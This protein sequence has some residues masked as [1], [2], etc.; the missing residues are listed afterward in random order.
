M[1]VTREKDGTIKV[2][3]SK[4]ITDMAKRFGL[5]DG[6][7]VR[8][9]DTP[10]LST[11]STGQDDDRDGGGERADQQHYMELIGSLM[12]AAIS[13]RYDAAYKICELARHVVSPCK[14]HVNEAMRVL[15]YLVGTKEHCLVFK[16][17]QQTGTDQSFTVEAWTDSDWASNTVHRKST[18]GWI[19]RVNGN[20]VSWQS[21]LQANVALSSCEAELYAC[22]TGALE[23][24]YLR[25]LLVELGLLNNNRSP[26]SLIHMDNQSAM[27]TAQNGIR[28]SDRNKHV[29]VRYHWITEKL[30]RREI[31][32]V[33]IRTEDQLADILTKPLSR[34]PFK[35]IMKLLTT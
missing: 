18:T 32:L 31:E 11:G 29:D 6:T 30:E 3:Q 21:K 34:Q 14:R 4:Y 10:A 26:P 16:P 8:T 2:D 28:S 5:G 24:A 15:R 9:S 25:G 23:V 27:K 35:H 12:Y 7:S 33:W 17:G 22:T 19:A 13:T 1:K 20:I